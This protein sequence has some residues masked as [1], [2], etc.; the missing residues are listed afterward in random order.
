MPNKLYINSRNITIKCPRNDVDTINNLSNIPIYHKNRVNSEFVVSSYYIKEVLKNFRGV[1]EESYDTLPPNILKIIDNIEHKK[2]TTQRLSA[3]GPEGEPGFL[4]AH[5]QVG[6][7][8]AMVHD[9]FCF[10]YDTRTGKTPMSLQIIKDNPT[11]KWLIVAPLVLLDNAWLEDA[12]KFFPGMNIVKLWATSKPKR[13]K[14]FE[15]HSN[16]YIINNESFV[17]FLPEIQKLGI[18]GVFLDE[19]SSLKSNSSKFGKAFVEF[20]QDMQRCYMLSGSPAPNGEWEYYRQLQCMDNFAVPQSYTQFERMFFDNISYNPQFKQLKLK[21]DMKEKLT[22][23]ISRYALYVDKSDVLDLPGRSFEVVP[24]E[25]SPKIK[26]AYTVMKKELYYE[27]KDDQMVTAPSASAKIN[28]LRQISSGFIYD[29]D[30]KAFLIDL[31]K[32]HALR[33]LV[34]RFGNKQILIWANYK[35]EFEVIKEILGKD[36]CVIVNGSVDAATKNLNIQAFKTG[37]AQYMIANPA[38]ADKGL[39]LTNAHICIYFSMNYSYELFYQSRDRIY[40]G[41]HSQPKF[42]EYYFMEVVGSLDNAI[43]QAVENKGD[44]SMAIL[45]ELRCN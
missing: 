33:E 36:S 25:M 37:K 18:T 15:K 9:R 38:S 32:F 8:L 6:R 28:K 45:N 4:M 17:S 23:I 27:L 41:K 12:E 30:G 20:A 14:Q 11:I 3:F 13:L 40:G 29:E 31:H 16:V 2:N 35:Y 24:V 22:E 42:C 44:M 1:D 26:E 7:E 43:R 10:F 5:Q 21:Y 34:Q 19:S 39:T